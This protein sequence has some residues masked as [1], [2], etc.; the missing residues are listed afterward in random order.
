M[1]TPGS[2]SPLD[3]ALAAAK[4]RE[5]RQGLWLAGAGLAGVVG[6]LGT[7]VHRHVTQ[8]ARPQNVLTIVFLASVV[9][10]GVGLHRALWA[11][12]ADAGGVPRPVRPWL[13]LVLTLVT[14]WTLAQIAGL[15]SGALV[16]S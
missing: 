15:V 14:W 12:R 2:P 4:R 3:P 9:L 16:R 8:P 5:R 11:P 10:Y 13:S 7:M 1:E 6:A